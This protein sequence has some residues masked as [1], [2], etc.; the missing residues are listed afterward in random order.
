MAIIKDDAL[1]VYHHPEPGL[2]YYDIGAEWKKLTGLCM[3]FAVWVVN[4]KFA[5]RNCD[6]LRLVYSRITQGFQNGYIKKKQAIDSILKDK[7]FSFKELSDY[8]EIIKWRFEPEQKYALRTFYSLAF[9]MNLIEYV[10]EIKMV[11]IFK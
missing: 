2:Y 6:L 7:P 11:E 5:A 10:P 8:L 3:V 4:R 9:K 1:Y